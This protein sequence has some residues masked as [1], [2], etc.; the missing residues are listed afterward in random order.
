MRGVQ[1]DS[2]ECAADASSIPCLA[3]PTS[4]NLAVTSPGV[5]EFGRPGYAN[6]R[7][8]RLPPHSTYGCPKWVPQNAPDAMQINRHNQKTLGLWK[9]FILPAIDIRDSLVRHSSH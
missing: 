4:R 6:V 2:M 7:Q 9:P 8:W 1:G 3:V 5:N